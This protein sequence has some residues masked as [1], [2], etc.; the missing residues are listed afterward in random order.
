MYKQV[1]QLL[2]KTIRCDMIT[3]LVV[4]Q[5]TLEVTNVEGT[6]VVRGAGDI[7]KKL[8]TLNANV[9]SDPQVCS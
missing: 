8:E 4:F 2:N 6:E 9:R 7:Y 3:T 1:Y 5:P